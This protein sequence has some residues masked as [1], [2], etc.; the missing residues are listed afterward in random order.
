LKGFSQ[1]VSTNDALDALSF[2]NSPQGTGVVNKAQIL[3]GASTAKFAFSNELVRISNN[4]AIALPVRQ[5][6]TDA[7]QTYDKSATNTY[8][9]IEAFVKAWPF[10]EEDPPMT[11]DTVVV[12]KRTL[13]IGSSAFFQLQGFLSDTNIP[14]FY[15]ETV[16]KSFSNRFHKAMSY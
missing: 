16:D 15:R 6:A 4:S 3:L 9:E 13:E 8:Q 10:I 12:Y 2:M 11:T 14:S 7:L 1:N 5:S